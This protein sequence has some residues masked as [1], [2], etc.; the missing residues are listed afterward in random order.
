M[1]T[2]LVAL[3]AAVLVHQVA[4]VSLRDV[5][6]FSSYLVG[7][8]VLPGTAVWRLVDPRQRDGRRPLAEDLAIGALVGYVLEFPAYLVWLA[9]GVPRLYLVWPVLVL[10]AAWGLRRRHP[11]LHLGGPTSGGSWR[12]TTAILM[13][14]VVC[15]FARHA[16]SVYPATG[17]SLRNPHVDE[18]FHL[19]LAVSLRRVFPAEFPFAADTPMEYHWLSH[20]HVAAAS[21]V[22]GIESLTLLRTLS[23]PTL[24]LVVAFATSQVAVRLTGVAWVQPVTLAALL[25]APASFTGWRVDNLEALLSP[26]LM[27]SPSAGFVNAA[28]L[29]GVLLVVEMLISRRT[30]WSLM[31]MSALT[32]VAMAGAKST[33]LPTFMAGLFGATV[34]CSLLERRLHRVGALLTLTSVAAFVAAQAFFFGGGAHGLEISPLRLMSLQGQLRPSLLDPDGTMSVPVELLLVVGYLAYLSLGASL[35]ALF[36]RGGW[37]RPERMFLVITCAAGFGA[38]LTFHQVNYSEY[39]F[40]YVVMLVLVLGAVLGLQHVVEPLPTRYATIVVTTGEL[41]TGNR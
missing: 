33:S 3:L 5:V 38:A 36:A 19:S 15:W 32:F 29:L 13:A 2:A 17:A 31:G 6:A 30:G 18:P 26:R 16:W 4:D 24:F 20:L 23:L 8:I 11:I 28:L 27:V 9:A 41:F 14:Y 1:P 39:Y 10:V 22:T 40:Q 7:W 35:I 12:W 25:V 21:W 34:L 37:R